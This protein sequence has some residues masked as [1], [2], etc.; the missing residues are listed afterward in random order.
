MEP[1]ERAL[2]PRERALG[3]G[4]CAF[5]FFLRHK[6]RREP[7]TRGG[8]RTLSREERGPQP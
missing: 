7:R 1:C 6:T 4:G 3:I 5:L 2:E 8:A